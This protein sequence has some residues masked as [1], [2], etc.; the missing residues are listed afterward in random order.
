MRSLV[1]GETFLRGSRRI[2]PQVAGDGAM[3]DPA[4]G[5]RFLRAAAGSGRRSQEGGRCELRSPSPSMCLGFPAS[6]ASGEAVLGVRIR[7]WGG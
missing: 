4:A 2:R 6:P 7:G 3:R 5:E 1:V